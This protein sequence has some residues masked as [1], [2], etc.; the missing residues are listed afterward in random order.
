MINEETKTITFKEKH[1]SQNKQICELLYSFDSNK[2]L[3]KKSTG[4][5]FTHAMCDYTR[6]NLIILSPN[7]SMIWEKAKG[8]YK[9]KEFFS[10]GGSDQSYK[11]VELLEYLKRTPPQFQNAVV[12]LNSEWLINTKNNHELWELLTTFHVFVDEIH[13]YV[14]DSSYRTPQGEALE[15]IYREILGKK[16]LSTAT[17]IPYHFDIPKELGFGVITFARA[18]NPVK[19]LAYSENLMDYKNF[20][21]KELADGRKVAVF[22]NNEMIHTY[23]P[24]QIKES[25][26]VNLCG[27][28]LKIKLLPK[29]RGINTNIKD[30]KLIYLSS[31]H[32]AGYDLNPNCSILIISEQGTPAF[33]INVNDCVQ[34]YGRCRNTVYKALYINVRAKYDFQGKSISYPEAE[35]EVLKEIIKYDFK[36]KQVED[37]VQLCREMDL[38]VSGDYITS[39]GYPNRGE[40][41]SSTLEKVHDYFQYNDEKRVELFKSYNFE[42]YPYESEVRNDTE[43]KRPNIGEQLKNLYNG[44]RYLYYDYLT[45][46]ENLKYKKSAG[47]AYKYGMMY[48]TIYLIREFDIEPCKEMMENTRMRPE[49]L[50]DTLDKWLRIN[51]P[52]SYLTEQLTKQQVVQI[53]HYKSIL[54][55]AEMREDLV[56]QWHM[57]YSMY[58]VSVGN[59]HAD[60]KRHLKVCEIAGNEKII[61]SANKDKKH[62]TTIAKQDARTAVKKKYGEV[63][64]EDEKA[65]D[66]V[67]KRSFKRIDGKQVERED[68]EI[69]MEQGE[70]KYTNMEKVSIQHKK[71]INMII[72]LMHMGKGEYA[73]VRTGNRE[74]GAVTEVSKKLR[75]LV[76][77]LYFEEDITSANPQFCDRLF[78]TNNAF[79]VYS[80]IMKTTGKTREEAKVMFNTFLNNHRF[81]VPKAHAFYRD[82]CLYPDAEALALAKLT[83]DVPSGTFF[84]IMTEVEDDLM[85][86]LANYLDMQSLRFHDALIIPAWECEGKPLPTLFNGFRF[87][88]GSFNS[89]DEYAGETIELKDKQF[90]FSDLDKPKDDE[91]P[92]LKQLMDKLKPIDE[93]DVSNLQRILNEYNQSA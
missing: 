89:K 72:Q 66:K 43:L 74:Y 69:K 47:F 42:L 80:N 60:I 50:F 32:F 57:F 1:A 27:A 24:S 8:Q 54:P 5:G 77:L 40:I 45:I 18:N 59:Y 35:K 46:K 68:L 14:G 26:I 55:D 7:N 63:T 41:G 6:G 36:V 20:I 33:R 37:E 84:A 82:K 73:N 44:E 70:G 62:R 38:P 22:S 10:I 90:M 21:N 87:H 65:I 48:L 81:E 11:L 85:S 88:I 12:N 58:K 25:E 13:Q 16:I 93:G 61:T 71:V 53:Q 4:L 28:S 3:I 78:K 79:D 67:I 31:S 92:N 39:T 2:Y 30:A 34:A 15:L 49:R 17:P 86:S 91:K 52:M 51:C 76:P 29:N 83:A 19:K 23:T 64:P 75:C 9:C 56:R